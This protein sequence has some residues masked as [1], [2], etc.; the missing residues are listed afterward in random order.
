[1]RRPWP[2]TS[3]GTVHLANS[4]GW[5]FLLSASVHISLPNTSK[6]QTL[7]TFEDGLPAAV[8]TELVDMPYELHFPGVIVSGKRYELD[9]LA[10]SRRVLGVAS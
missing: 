4:T 9:A 6:L 8:A 5:T 10:T 7:A 1:M 2:R 3:H